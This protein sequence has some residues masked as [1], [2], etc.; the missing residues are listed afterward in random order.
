LGMTQLG[1]P[2]GA[3]DGRGSWVGAEGRDGVAFDGG[4]SGVIVALV[5]SGV[6][7]LLREMLRDRTLLRLERQRQATI[8]ALLMGLSASS[9]LVQSEAGHC[10]VRLAG[11]IREV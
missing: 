9:V 2:P 5:V 6:L 11:S 3:L 1:M 7:V 4:W 10:E 8:L